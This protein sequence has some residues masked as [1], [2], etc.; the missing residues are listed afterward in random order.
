MQVAY[1]TLIG[2]FC[3]PCLAFAIEPIGT[4]GQPLPEQHAFLSNDTILRVVPTHIQVVDLPTGTVIDEFGE[5]T[6][7]SDVGTESDCIAFSDPE[8]LW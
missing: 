8:S 2:I 7:Y 4:I 5:R 1:I 6:D 3:L